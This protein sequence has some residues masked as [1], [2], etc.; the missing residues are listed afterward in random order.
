[1]RTVNG[2]VD[3]HYVKSEEGDS[4]RLVLVRVGVN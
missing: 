4:D 1:M 3:C 2:C